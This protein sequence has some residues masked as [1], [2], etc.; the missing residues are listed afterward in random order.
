MLW[1]IP[2][3]YSCILCQDLSWFKSTFFV[4]FSVSYASSDWQCWL[5][6]FL[7]YLAHINH[8]KFFDD[9]CAFLAFKCPIDI[10]GGKS[11]HKLRFTKSS[12]NWSFV[13]RFWR[14]NRIY[15]GVIISQENLNKQMSWKTKIYKKFTEVNARFSLLNLQ[16]IYEGINITP[17]MNLKKWI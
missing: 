5:F 3:Y 17:L 6:Y 13:F 10:W 4:A 14:C 16:Y 7:K 2:V 12:Y 11:A 9:R 15:G 8:R 1:L